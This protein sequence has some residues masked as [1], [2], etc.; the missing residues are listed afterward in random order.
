MI[1]LSK[2]RVE[3]V[4]DYQEREYLGDLMSRQHALGDKKLIGQRLV[5][6]AYYRGDVV[7]VLYFDKSVDRN[8]YRDQEIGWSASQ[9]K[10]RK[11]HVVNNSRFLICSEYEGTK[12]LASKLLSLTANRLSS[13]WERQYGLPILA[14]ETYVD[15]DRRGNIG[16]CYEAAGWTNLGYSSGF[17]NKGGERTH[18]KWYFLK[19]LHKDSFLALRTDI[20]H[21]LLTGVK[22]VSGESNN[23]FVFDA[24]KIDLKS[25]Q[26]G[27]SSVKDPRRKQG[28]RYEFLPFLSLCVSA[29]LSGYTQ[30]RQ[31]ADFI[32]KLPAETRVKFGLRGDLV[33][34]ETTISY[35]LR[36]IDGESLQQALTAWLL[37]TFGDIGNVVSLDGKSIKAT[38]KDLK[39]Q[40][41]FLNVYASELGIVINQVPCSAGAGEAKSAQKVVKEDKNL[42]G[43]IILADALHTNAELVGEIQKKTPRTSSLSKI[44]KSI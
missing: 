40:S 14:I 35:F 41:K 43:K 21:A 3:P 12:N 2:V 22:P 9:R 39:E 33:P 28:Q 42:E 15:P 20:P 38:S 6:G 27:L 10:E 32:S 4:T 17:Q 29:V 16:T 23:N 19:A 26:Q 13:D 18:S 36:G 24:S 44:I 8:K 37:E 25:L 31:I 5:Y 1:D 7:G 30:Y 11:K 34:S